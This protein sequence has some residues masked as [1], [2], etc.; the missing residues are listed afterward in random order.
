[1]GNWDDKILRVKRVLSLW[2]GPEGGW[3]RWTD[4]AAR[5]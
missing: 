3:R 1:M 5:P 4:I 2:K